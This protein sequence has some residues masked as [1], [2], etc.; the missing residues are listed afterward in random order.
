MGSGLGFETCM[1]NIG[2][3]ALACKTPRIRTLSCA[4]NA[5]LPKVSAQ[6]ITVTIHATK[7][8]FFYKLQQLTIG[9]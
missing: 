5:W 9:L 8:A 1:T 2:S 6:H 4:P 7:A 3:H